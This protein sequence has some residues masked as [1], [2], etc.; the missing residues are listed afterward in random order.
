MNATIY[1]VRIKG[2]LDRQWTGWFRGMTLA[3][4][5]DGDT[6]L[7]GPVEDQAALHGL[8][9]KLRDHGLTLL[10][11]NRLDDEGGGA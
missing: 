11:I 6:L 8:F 1:Q 10:S 9:R 7:T 2:L 5:A 3:A 4:T